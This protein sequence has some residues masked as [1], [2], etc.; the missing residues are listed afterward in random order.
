M[1]AL[2]TGGAGFIGRW[3]VKKLL[4]EKH[5][6]RVIDNLD[7]GRESNLDEFKGH[8]LLKDV[9]Y[10]DILNPK[11]LG[12][13][14]KCKPDVTYH[15]AAQINV[16]ESL[17][18]PKKA[19]EIN[20]RGTYN[21]LEQCR[22]TGTKLVL[23]GTCLVYDI[24]KAHK[25]INE[26][27]PVKPTS[28]YAASKLSSEILAESYFH[29][30]GLPVVLCRPF[31]TYGPY[32]KYNIE[33]GVVSIFVKQAMKGESLKIYGDGSQ[34]RDLLYV[35]DCVDF[36]YRASQCKE[37]EG[38]TINAGSGKDI[39]I[40]DLARMV[41]QDDSRIQFMDHHHP[42]SEIKKLLCDYSKARAMLNWNPRFDLAMGIQLVKQQVENLCVSA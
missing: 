4:E 22:P 12:S 6:V 16:Q 34:T 9:V 30:Y 31:N 8:P 21:V 24:A 41:C 37:A 20:I 13:L 10:D 7:N 27:H 33:G 18:N 19:Y 3:L 14:F 42:Q 38:E 29:S 28:P 25:P 39:A 40:L 23:T 36:I 26:H 15:L 5:E 2:V 17:E 35:E 11:A 1:K 32:Q